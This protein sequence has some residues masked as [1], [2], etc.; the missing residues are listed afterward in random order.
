MKNNRLFTVAVIANLSL[1]FLIF[2]YRLGA[3]FLFPALFAAHIG[4]FFLNLKACKRLW[5]II[6]LGITQAA[7][8]FCVYRQ[9][10][11]LYLRY[12]ADDPEG[13]L[14]GVMGCVVGVVISAILSGI[15]LVRF[16]ILRYVAE[17]P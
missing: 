13:R 10:I 14:L 8:T 4:L 12:I 15:L 6:T 11:G 17:R 5:Q 3:P 1:L 7:V 9:S 2:F 16:I